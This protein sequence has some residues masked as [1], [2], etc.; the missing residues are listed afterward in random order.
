MVVCG[1]RRNSGD[2]VAFPCLR[3]KCVP[4][5]CYTRRRQLEI[6]W[7]IAML[8]TPQSLVGSRLYGML[9]GRQDGVVVGHMTLF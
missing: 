2:S 3:V 6:P 5:L 7:D 1:S 8:Y 9:E 4:H